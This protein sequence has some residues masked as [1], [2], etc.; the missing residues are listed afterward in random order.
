MVINILNEESNSLSVKDIT[1]KLVKK[2]PEKLEFKSSQFNDNK[3][4]AQQQIYR[5][6]HQ[7]TIND[8]VAFFRDKKFKPLK[9]GLIEENQEKLELESLDEDFESE[10]GIVYILSTNTFTKDAKE[11]VKI[12]LTTRTMKDRIKSLYTTG[13]PFEFTVLREYTTS[14]YEQLERAMHKL[15]HN[16]RPNQ[17]REFFTK[18]CLD[19]ADEIYELHKKIEN[20]N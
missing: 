14:S 2:Y 8:D 18:D 20:I 9:I 11:L 1:S 16:F 5:E 13:V 15:L 7:V 4:L 12:G 19:Y 17:T 3:K 6:I 10:T